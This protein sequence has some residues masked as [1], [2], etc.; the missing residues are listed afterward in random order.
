[1]KIF[2]PMSLSLVIISHSICVALVTRLTTELGLRI[3]SKLANH[4]PFPH[5]R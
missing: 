2:L 1:M 3:V 4:G 5:I